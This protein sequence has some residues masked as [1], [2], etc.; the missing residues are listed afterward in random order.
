[1][2]LNQKS[3]D[4]SAYPVWDALAGLP[5]K[6]RAAFDNIFRKPAKP[7]NIH[8][9]GNLFEISFTTTLVA[10]FCAGTRC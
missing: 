6:L 2:E 10:D 8:S 3:S 9:K 7:Q 4:C 1:M 5:P